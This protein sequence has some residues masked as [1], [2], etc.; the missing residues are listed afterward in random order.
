VVAEGG[1]WVAAEW[2]TAAA[3]ASSGFTVTSAGGALGGTASVVLETSGSRAGTAVLET[4][5]S[6][7]GTA[8]L[9]TWGSRAGTAVLETWVAFTKALGDAV[10]RLTVLFI[11]V[12]GCSR[13]STYS[14]AGIMVSGEGV[15]PRWP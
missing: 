8:V 9:E 14:L 12:G 11:A 6:R 5:G 4:W 7:A 3:C 2:A 1:S 13:S 15:E 10:D